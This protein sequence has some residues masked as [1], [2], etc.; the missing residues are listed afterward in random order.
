MFGVK[1]DFVAGVWEGVGRYVF[2]NGEMVKELGLSLIIMLLIIS[3][4][5]LSNLV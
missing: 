5:S 4:R 1:G 3:P 2:A